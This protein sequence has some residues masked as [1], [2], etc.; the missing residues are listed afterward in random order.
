MLP[1]DQRQKVLQDIWRRAPSQPLPLRLKNL[2]RAG[3]LVMLWRGIDRRDAKPLALVTRMQQLPKWAKRLGFF[4][5]VLIL[6]LAFGWRVAAVLLVLWAIG[7]VAFWLFML[8]K[9]VK[10]D[11]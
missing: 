9:P 10:G 7:D 1:R 2:H 5:L 4:L 11:Y 6:D 8:L 3:L